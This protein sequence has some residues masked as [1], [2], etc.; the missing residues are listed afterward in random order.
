MAKIKFIYFDVGGVLLRDFS[1]TTKWQNLKRDL[2]IILPA[3][4][5]IFEK[6]WAKHTARICVDEDIDSFFDEFKTAL[7]IQTAP[8]YSFLFDFIN[9]F[10]LNPS[11]WQLVEKLQAN[12]QLG[13]LTNMYPRMCAELVHRQLIPNIAWKT[14]ID[15]S[16]VG[17]QKPEEKIYKIAE[18]R[19]KVDPTEILFIDNILNNLLPAQNLGWETLLYQ[20]QNPLLSNQEILEKLDFKI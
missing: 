16:Q 2:G 12:Y 7:K 17:F 18:D 11:I 19:A 5:E 1:G 8:G 15:S 6:I 10:E 9:R 3:D 13:L 4:D 20:T 14:I